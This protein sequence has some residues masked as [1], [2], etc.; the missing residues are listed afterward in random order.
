MVAVV[1]RHIL[2]FLVYDVAHGRYQKYQ[3][4]TASDNLLFGPNHTGH[5]NDDIGGCWHQKCVVFL[6]IIPATLCRNRN[7]TMTWP[8]KDSTDHPASCELGD[9]ESILKHVGTNKKDGFVMFCLNWRPRV[10]WSSFSPY[11]IQM[12]GPHGAQ[13]P[14]EPTKGMA[15][16]WSSP[17]KL[18][19]FEKQRGLT[20][21]PTSLSFFLFKEWLHISCI[22]SVILYSATSECIPHCSTTDVLFVLSIISSHYTPLHPP[23]YHFSH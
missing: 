6:A 15:K 17:P 9:G 11:L 18:N 22:W 1:A 4:P 19:E 10:H 13:G 12:G 7:S 8:L 14:I 3:G 16:W 20:I 21:P 2:L 23:Q 5:K